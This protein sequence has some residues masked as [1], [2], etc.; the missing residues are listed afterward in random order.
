MHH[1]AQAWLRVHTGYH[2]TPQTVAAFA[3]GSTA[4]AAWLKLYDP[5]LQNGA[6][7]TYGS[8]QVWRQLQLQPSCSS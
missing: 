3:L 6:G 5:A 1:C 7:K 2:T 8:S 4:P